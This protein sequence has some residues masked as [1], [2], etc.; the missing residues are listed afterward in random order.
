MEL[1]QVFQSIRKTEFKVKKI[2][3][4]YFNAQKIEKSDPVEYFRM[5]AQADGS[6]FLTKFKVR[7]TLE[8]ILLNLLFPAEN[9][10]SAPQTAISFECLPGRELTT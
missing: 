6:L 3:R 10:S 5:E 2:K 1:A 7:G 9:P 4:M 8:V